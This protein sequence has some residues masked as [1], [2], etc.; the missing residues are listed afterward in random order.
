MEK[1]TGIKS[2]EAHSESLD[3]LLR[4]LGVDPLHGLTAA[5]AEARLATHGANELPSPPPPNAVLKFLAQFA[6]PIVLTLLVAAVV[7]VV[8]ASANSAMPFFARYADA[9]AIGLIVVINAVLGYYQER[10]AEKALDALKRMQ[11]PSA[12]ARRDGKVQALAAAKLIPK[13]IIKLKTKKRHNPLITEGY[14][15]VS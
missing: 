9:L 10:R 15:V 6:N 4:R 2:A 3:A 12:R 5:E 1:S 11:A 7:A 13:N 8:T 14:A